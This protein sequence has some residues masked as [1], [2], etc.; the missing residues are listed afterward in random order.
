MPL[1]FALRFPRFLSIEPGEVNEP[2]PDDIESFSSIFLHP[3]PAL[4]TDRQYFVCQLT[5]IAKERAATAGIEALIPLCL[6]DPDVDWKQ[7]IFMAAGSKG[8]HR[9]MAHRSWLLPGTVAFKDDRK[10][11][12]DV[13]VS[14][15]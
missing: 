12:D 3:S 8:I 15:E 11:L 5:S 6:E 4:Q 1:Q 9:W 10:I 2:L 13:S 7:L 14:D